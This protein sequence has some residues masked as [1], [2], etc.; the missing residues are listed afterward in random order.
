MTDS[1]EAALEPATV[2]GG[3]DDSTQAVPYLGIATRK[4]P[5]VRPGRV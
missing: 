5:A 4:C 1:L 2:G 3:A